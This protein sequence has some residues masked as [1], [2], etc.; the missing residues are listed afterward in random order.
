MLHYALRGHGFLWLGLS[1]TVGPHAD[2][3]DVQDPKLKIYRRKEA[4][5]RARVPVPVLPR[6]VAVP[7]LRLSATRAGSSPPDALREADR[8]L[9][10]RYSPPGVVV[11]A[12][13]HVVQ[14][15]GDTSP[16]LA[17]L[18]GRPSLHLLKMARDGVAIALRRALHRA[19]TENGGVREEGVHVAVPGGYREVA[20]EVVPLDDES[21]ASSL[22]VLFDEVSSVLAPAG[23]DGSS[24]DRLVAADVDLA[25]ENQR[26]R[27]E[28]ASMKEYLQSM[29]EQYE[30][31]S[32]EL[33]S[34]NEEVQSTNE[35]LQSINEELETSKEEIQSSN[36]ELATVNEELQGRN[37]ELSQSNN[38]MVNLLGSVNMAIVMLGRDL[39]IRR[40]TPAAEKVLNLIPTDVGRPVS[41]IKLPIEVPDLEALLLDAVDS[42]ATRE[43]EVRD[44]EG[45]WYLLR[46]RPYLTVENRI[47]GAVLMLIDIDLHKRTVQALD[48]TAGRFAL[49]ADTA[50]VLIW[51]M[52]P[53]ESCDIN[54]AYRE[55]IGAGASTLGREQWSAFI[56]PDDREAYV[57]RYRQ[58][59]V[60]REPFEA[61]VRL[62]RAD[63]AWRWMKS[64]AAP[65]T[66][67]D[68]DFLGYVG[69]SFD[70]D[71]LKTAESSLRDADAAKT[72]FL[73][74][75]AHEFRTPLSAVSNAVQILCLAAPGSER[76]QHAVAILSRQS[77][78]MAR[79]LDD[80][81]DLSRV[82]HGLVR[83]QKTRVDLVETLAH[84]IEV[85]T[86]ELVARGVQVEAALPDSP[87]WLDADPLRLDQVFMNLLV[88]A[89]K[90][91]G[92]GG[93]V[94]VELSRETTPPVDL[95]HSVRWQE[96]AVVR[97][98]D[99][100]EGL[101]RDMLERVFE[102]FVQI[103]AQRPNDRPGMGL[104]L[105]LA[106][107]LVELHE[108]TIAASSPGL[109]EGS[110]F[111]VRL[112][113]H[114]AQP[115]QQRV[116]SAARGTARPVLVVEDDA[117]AAASLRS[118]LELASFEVE[119]AADGRS[120]LAAAQARVPAII[121][122]DINMPGMSGWDLARE[123]RADPRFAQTLIIAIS[124]L[125][126]AADR[127]RSVAA[128]IDYH[129]VKPV[130]LQTLLGAFEEGRPAAPHADQPD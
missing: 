20:I 21:R 96:T 130:A 49:L 91:S 78:N 125:G 14:F 118:M 89:I 22:L 88:N 15:R 65:R 8:V 3:F 80:L 10:A 30:A 120:G 101:A 107:Q 19:R 23:G 127:Q 35:E 47:D 93:V 56:H 38:D 72:R 44:R 48:E 52:D 110:T 68:G 43:R 51:I 13:L 117:D 90:F 18:P 87:V 112:P 69:C 58:C 42:M 85:A 60:Q 119:V 113:V 122:L 7:P 115:P 86:Q 84:A 26:L 54:R 121:L 82:T 59:A 109:G 57:D 6:E 126:M 70:I 17:L 116:M 81:V 4:P 105:A 50:P 103:D 33:Q 114:P 32:E 46:A 106:R 16:Y 53:D 45:R 104:G 108:G 100:G 40:L 74:V 39:R 124:G 9:A 25:Q 67:R 61:L 5:L 37:A 94:R 73:A 129:F 55:F 11:D 41:D 97:I 24:P 98:R 128:G 62:R 34:A 12:D 64:V 95:P 1:E 83:L 102:P 66:T 71:D 92:R 36:E 29:V 77:A 27:H 2:L 111:T 75:L 79:L 31:S 123:L 63:G 99:H 76:F 28:L